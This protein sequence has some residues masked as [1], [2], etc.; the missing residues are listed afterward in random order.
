MLWTMDHWTAELELSENG[1]NL[2]GERIG[3]EP[4]QCASAN[5]SAREARQKSMDRQASHNT[6]AWMEQWGSDAR[7]QNRHIDANAIWD[8]H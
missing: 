2:Q 1:F 5:A 7:V 8:K 4:A 6:S 3:E